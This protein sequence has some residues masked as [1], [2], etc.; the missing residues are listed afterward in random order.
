MKNVTDGLQ[1]NTSGDDVLME[2]SYAISGAA[3]V[4]AVNLSKGIVKKTVSVAIL[5]S[6]HKITSN[7]E[8][9]N[10]VQ[11]VLQK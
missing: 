8:K 5:E 11:V 10:L 7:R 4:G 9:K 1:E 6:K 3:A 2:K